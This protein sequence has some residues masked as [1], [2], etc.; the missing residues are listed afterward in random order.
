[1]QRVDVLNGNQAAAIGAALA[2][3]GVIAAYPITPQTPVVE[4]LTEYAVNGKIDAAMSEVESE[5]SAMSVVTGASLAGSRTFTATASQG[6]ALMYEPYFRAST[7]RLPIVMAIVNREMISPQSV[8]GGQ[9]DSMSV[10]DAGWLQMYAEDNQEILDMV[11]QAF[12][13]A[14][15]QRVLLPINIC[16]DG[17]YLSH[18]TEKVLVPEQEKVDAFLG[19]YEPEHIK[20]DPDKPMS[21]DP[22]TN[23]ALLMEYRYKHLK[24][25]QEALKV[26]EEV[27][28]EYGK[29]F[30]RSYGGAIETYKMEDA[31]YALITVG[32]VSGAAKEAIDAK[33]AEGIKV[34]LVRI[35]MVRPFPKEQICQA[36]ANVKAFG[37]VDKNVSFGWDTG[38][39]YQEVKSA[40]Y[41]GKNHVP[42]VPVIGGLGGEDISIQMLKD[43]VDTIV[44][45]AEKGQNHD[46]VWLMVKEGEV[47]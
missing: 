16:Y 29:L 21:V 19:T 11:V 43:T 40:M 28:Q 22:L 41:E 26:L 31:E 34:G 39:I 33:R 17:F 8:W 47:R 18:M 24:A 12:K 27:D 35:R 36:L 38:I 20:L 2:K 13:I 46:A 30:G 42:S 7:L 25:Q 37:V 44:E 15:D 6:L 4:Y 14:E 9:Q 23:G 3:P 1:M 10:R 32:S 5:L 45:T